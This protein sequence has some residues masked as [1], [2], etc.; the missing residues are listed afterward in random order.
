VSRVGAGIRIWRG[1]GF[2]FYYSTGLEP[3]VWKISYN[4]GGQSCPSLV[5]EV[6]QKYG[7]G[8]PSH[9]ETGIT[10]WNVGKETLGLSPTLLGIRGCHLFILDAEAQLSDIQKTIQKCIWNYSRPNA[11]TDFFRATPSGSPSEQATEQVRRDLEAANAHSKAA[12]QRSPFG[13]GNN[14]ATPAEQYICTLAM[15][16]Y[17]L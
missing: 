3:K 11:I 10:Y 14:V 17:E 2:A 6:Q 7:V 4:F 16:V 12:E 15:S 1:D 9:T 8:E 5:G 13:P